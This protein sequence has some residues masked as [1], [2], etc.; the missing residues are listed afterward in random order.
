MK[1]LKAT[2]SGYSSEELSQA[3]KNSLEGATVGEFKTV[4]TEKAFKLLN[5][6][7]ES[8]EKS[9]YSERDI[10]QAWD[11]SLASK[12]GLGRSFDSRAF[13]ALIKALKEV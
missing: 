12:F 7:L 5:D 4:L 2:Q 8:P 9:R 10:R 3:W 11:S 1:N 13:Q 6:K